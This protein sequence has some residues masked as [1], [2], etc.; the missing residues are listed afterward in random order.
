MATLR[1][2][3]RAL[4]VEDRRC[5]H[6]RRLLRARM[7]LT[8]AEAVDTPALMCSPVDP[9]ST[10]DVLMLAA[11]R[12]TGAGDLGSRLQEL[13]VALRRLGSYSEAL[14]SQIDDATDLLVEALAADP[15]SCLPAVTATSSREG[16]PAVD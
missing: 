16:R 5:A 13:E 2:R 11:L 4:L 7:D 3:R 8:V 9:P 12:D 1:R 14:H 10:V 6:L 15:S